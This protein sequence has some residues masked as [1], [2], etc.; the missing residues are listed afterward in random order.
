[1]GTIV[2]AIVDGVLKAAFGYLTQIMEKRGL[3]QQGRNA[4]HS[5]DLQASV[6]EAKDAVK[7]QE[8]VKTMDDPAVDA[9]LEQLRH[10]GTP[11]PHG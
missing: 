5:D 2:S 8:T 7:T 10:P 1:M 6:N 3:I 4:Q 11:S 9:Q